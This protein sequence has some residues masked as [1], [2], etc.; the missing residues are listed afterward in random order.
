MKIARWVS[1]CCNKCTTYIY[2]TNTMGNGL[3]PE[4]KGC[5]GGC[6]VKKKQWIRNGGNVMKLWTTHEGSWCA[7]ESAFKLVGRIS[8]SFQTPLNISIHL[9]HVHHVHVVSSAVSCISI[10]LWL[11]GFPSPI[12]LQTE[13]PSAPIKPETR[14]CFTL[15][16]GAFTLRTFYDE[17]RDV[18]QWDYG[19]TT[20]FL[21][22]H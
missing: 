18:L 16:Q 15:W 5:C 12:V 13:S 4:A 17:T 8:N 11:L 2:I 7:Q 14:G 6:F 22:V 3:V 9:H 1:L 19:L 20:R 10:Y 21:I